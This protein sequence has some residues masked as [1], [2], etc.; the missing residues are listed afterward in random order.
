[1]GIRHLVQ[2]EADPGWLL[3]EDVGRGLAEVASRGLRF[4]LLVLPHQL[5]AAVELARRMPELPLV[6]D[7]A[8][9]PPLRDGNLTAWAAD[10][11]ALAAAGPVTCKLSGLVTEARPGW[12]VDDL[13]PAVDEV[14]TAFGPS[15]TMFGSD[16]PVCEASGG[17]ARWVGA[18][19]QLLSTLSAGE[20]DDVLWGTAGRFYGLDL[21]AP[22]PSPPDPLP[23]T[24]HRRHHCSL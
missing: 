6:L 14:L 17:W 1:V 8:A 12:A 11:H 5:P 7:H 20:L 2:G 23:E 15:H 24:G 22:I 3:R 13:R 4:D 21:T 10:L 19:E 16:W 9:K 18:A